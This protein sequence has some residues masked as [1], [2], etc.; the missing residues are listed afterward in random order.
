M[1]QY[2]RAKQCREGRGQQYA[3]QLDQSCGYFEDTGILPMKKE[4]Q[5][6]SSRKHNHVQV[7]AA[8]HS[9][10]GENAQHG[11][12]GQGQ[13]TEHNKHAGHIPAMESVK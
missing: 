9:Q 13:H 2:V 12:G 3:T 7:D 1:E 10:H 4:F 6:S 8:C 11:N 5:Y